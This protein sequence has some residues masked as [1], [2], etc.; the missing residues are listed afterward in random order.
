M[1][2]FLRASRLL[3]S[4]S[5]LNALFLSSLHAHNIKI[6]ASESQKFQPSIDFKNGIHTIDTVLPDVNAVSLNE[7]EIFDLDGTPPFI[8]V[9][10]DTKVLILRVNGKAPTQLKDAHEIDFIRWGNKNQDLKIV[11]ENPLGIYA[12]NCTMSGN[13]IHLISESL[14]GIEGLG[15]EAPK[16]SLYLQSNTVNLYGS[17]R[18]R[19]CRITGGKLSHSGNIFSQDLLDI[20]LSYGLN[21]AGRM[22]SLL[23]NIDTPFLVNTKGQEGDIPPYILAYDGA[24]SGQLAQLQIKTKSLSNDGDLRS[25]GDIGISSSGT[26][27]NTGFITSYAN[28]KLE[29]LEVMNKGRIDAEGNAEISSTGTLKN[30]GVIRSKSHMKIEAPGLI[31]KRGNIVSSGNM[32]ISGLN[33]AKAEAV[34]N[35][36]GYIEVQGPGYIHAKSIVNFPSGFKEIDKVI[37]ALDR[38]ETPVNVS[39]IF[40]EN[41]TEFPFL[42]V[43]QRQT[44]QESWVPSWMQ[45]HS[46][47]KL[48]TDY[49]E[50][51]M[52]KLF[53]H[54]VLD[55]TQNKQTVIE[56][57][58]N[59][60]FSQWDLVAEDTRDNSLA[61]QL[62][63]SPGGIAVC[64]FNPFCWVAATVSAASGADWQSSSIDAVRNL[65]VPRVSYVKNNEVENCDFTIFDWG[66]R[67]KK[68]GMHCKD[69]HNSYPAEMIVDG[70]LKGEIKS[71]RMLN[72]EKPKGENWKF[73]LKNTDANRISAHKID[74]SI[75]GDAVIQG[76]IETTKDSLRLYAKNIAHNGSIKSAKDVNLLADE[77]LLIKTLAD[78]ITSSIKGRAGIIAKGDVVMEGKKTLES[79]GAEVKGENIIARSDGEIVI[80]SKKILSE[81]KSLIA[82]GYNEERRKIFCTDYVSN[83]W[84]AGKKIDIKALKKVTISGGKFEAPDLISVDVTE[85]DIVTEQIKK[86][87]EE[88]INKKQSGF[89]GWLTAQYE[90]AKNYAEETLRTALETGE[91][92]QIKLN[93]GNNI[94]LKS[95]NLTTGIF[96][97]T[98]EGNITLSGGTTKQ[99]KCAKKQANYFFSSD[100]KGRYHIFGHS[101][102]EACSE[103]ENVDESLFNVGKGYINAKNHVTIAS[104]H[105]NATDGKWAIQGDQG[106]H[107]LALNET[108]SFVRRED[109]GG[110]YFDLVATPGEFSVG[111]GLYANHIQNK[112][113]KA[114][115]KT[116]SFFAE[117]GMDVTSKEGIIEFEGGR[118]L[119][120]MNLNAKSISMS[121]SKGQMCI[122][123]FEVLAELSLRA[124][125]KSR[126]MKALANT[127][128]VAESDV[129]VWEDGVNLGFKI[130][131]NGVEIATAFLMPVEG[132]V[133]ARAKATA[134][135]A[136][137]C[138]E[139]MS[140]PSVVG[141]NIVMT[142]EQCIMLEAADI[143]GINGEIKAKCL[144]IKAASA[145]SSQI[146]VNAS[147][148]AD[149]PVM[150]FTAP[151]ASIEGSFQQ[152]QQKNHRNAQL[153]FKNKLKMSI[154]EEAIIEGALIQ[155]KELEAE[156][157]SLLI[158]SLQDE[159]TMGGFKGSLSLDLKAFGNMAKTLTGGGAGVNSYKR[160]SVN[161]MTALLGTGSAKVIVKGLAKV[162]GALIANAEKNPDGTYTDKGNLQLQMGQLVQEDM[163]NSY[164]GVMLG[165]GYSKS[166]N[167]GLHGTASAEFGFSNQH[168]QSR[169]TLGQGNVKLSSDDTASTEAFE[170]INRDVNK[171]DGQLEGIDIK[172]LYATIPIPNLSD[173]GVHFKAYLKEMGRCASGFD[174]FRNSAREIFR[175]MGWLPDQNKPLTKGEKTWRELFREQIEFS[176]EM[177]SEEAEQ[178]LKDVDTETKAT[179]EKI[180]KEAEKAK[181]EGD[182]ERAE[183]TDFAKA[184]LEQAKIQRTQ[185]KVQE[186]LQKKAPNEGLR[187]KAEGAQEFYQRRAEFSEGAARQFA[188]AKNEQIAQRLQGQ[189]GDYESIL[190]RI[191]D[192][193]GLNQLQNI[194]RMTDSGM[195]KEAAVVFDAFHM[196]Y[197][198]GHIKTLGDLFTGFTGGAKNFLG[199]TF[200]KVAHKA[201]S[202]AFKDFF[203]LDGFTFANS[204]EAFQQEEV[205]RIMKILKPDGSWV[206]E[207]GSG[208]RIRELNGGEE[209]AGR[210]IKELTKNGAYPM[211]EI[212]NKKTGERVGFRWDLPGDVGYVT[213]RQFSMSGPPTININFLNRGTDFKLKFKD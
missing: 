110:L 109:S 80:I 204:P 118:Y 7:F 134:G 59:S 125:I 27:E 95:F 100:S 158:Q 178:I 37:T 161:E 85:G 8:T 10:D 12:S 160:T 62:G 35:E 91:T 98:A 41:K 93:A 21:N 39:L 209:A 38:T 74:L 24:S 119:G 182:S 141:Q 143:Q 198:T 25:Q 83:H 14:I 11:V 166:T 171:A 177:T 167:K 69:T 60:L 196:Q 124:G 75:E 132:G 94:D 126:L 180:Q 32:T 147:A 203:G 17:V 34:T 72:W 199:T 55:F 111:V 163:E 151:S 70:Y 138:F 206:G 207:S 120:N 153:I 105:G 122:D 154:E 3:L 90:E 213:Y 52:G 79:V 212:V 81:F 130:F 136:M 170:K 78:E 112:E 115:K 71:F 133:W 96:N 116:N 19:E 187:K 210:F 89:W 16:S 99:K 108:H 58:S 2:V 49:F 165:G 18:A 194:K 211:E 205:D 157:G 46:G 57:H 208:G 188:G 173:G 200:S 192:T 31:N 183:N 40:Q 30:T 155:A 66:S 36:S 127:I 159:M 15:L 202:Q 193:E 84:S 42:E 65:T 68:K 1:T 172:A 26:F 51:I 175:G 169:A 174:C 123:G 164:F 64:V 195:L 191:K 53:V 20:K 156:F 33:G 44:F 76:L 129:Q 142:A 77:V 103:D 189:M 190:T 107:F 113:Y 201:A 146:A 48:E 54:G 47:L 139:Y 106:V 82:Y 97:A 5:L 102:E 86:I 61:G 135:Y 131:S 197:C 67:A 179:E 13:E 9:D 6:Q 168:G 29:A 88:E 87:C 117:E 45:F 148:E 92:G 28:V 121:P 50:N 150:G 104:A 114:G 73:G 184:M 101:N 162:V 185:A 23:V 43:N 63:K 144:H 181:K 149:V 22:Q 137:R 186:I 56:Q 128:K 145:S 4:V 176:D 152:Q 140:V